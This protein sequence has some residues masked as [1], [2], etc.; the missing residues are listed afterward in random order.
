[1]SELRDLITA[2]VR[3]LRETDRARDRATEDG[4]D[5]V[6]HGSAIIPTTTG[7]K[8]GSNAQDVAGRLWVPVFT[9][10]MEEEA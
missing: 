2:M 10:T 9:G 5:Q 4:G 3:Q 8:T 1:M 7:I 6:I